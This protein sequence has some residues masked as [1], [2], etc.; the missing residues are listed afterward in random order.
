MTEQELTRL[1]VA[2]WRCPLF[3]AE[4]HASYMLEAM[5]YAQ[6]N[7]PRRLAHWLGQLGHESGRGLYTAEIWGPTPQQRRYEPTTD[8]SKALGNTRTGDGSRY[9]GRGLIQ[10]TGRANAR[11][12]TQRTRAALGNSMPDFEA[13]P[14][15]MQG[16]EWASFCGADYW[17]ARNLNTWA[18]ADNILTLTQRI[19]GGTNGL[20]DRQALTARAAQIINGA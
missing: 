15:L 14:R 12:F 1:L 5:A 7:T 18:D 11:S 10:L 16:A 6:I 17:R 8:L 4:L 9:R 19:N 13:A 20:P 2:V 3:R